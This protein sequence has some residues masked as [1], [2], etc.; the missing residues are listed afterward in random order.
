MPGPG[1][2]DDHV[3]SSSAQIP[4]RFFGHGRDPDSEQL[5]RPV[6]AGQT[7]GVAGVGLD[8]IPQTVGINVGAITSQATPRPLRTRPPLN[9][10]RRPGLVADPQSAR[11]AQPGNQPRTASSS[12]EIV[13]RSATSSPGLRIAA[14]IVFSWMASPRCG[15]LV[16]GGRLLRYVATSASWWLIHASC[17]TSPAVSYRLK[18]APEPASY[19]RPAITLPTC[20]IPWRDLRLTPAGH[21]EPTE[22]H[23]LRRRPGAAP[24]ARRRVVDSAIQASCSCQ[25][26]G[27]MDVRSSPALPLV[28]R[29]P[30][31]RPWS[32]STPRR[33]LTQLPPA[34]RGRQEE[35][36]RLQHAWSVGT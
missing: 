2:V 22:G 17:E 33:C 29:P 12:E 27:P 10:A 14:E 20:A 32:S 36:Q 28:P 19:L 9:L 13:S 30:I 31:Y 25:F 18:G 4:D 3:R 24:L 23:G 11:T 21:L 8:P 34:E 5:P 35:Q 7:P 26:S 6:K 1:P 15:G 16:G